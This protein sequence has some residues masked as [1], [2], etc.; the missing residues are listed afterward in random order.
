VHARCRSKR[1]KS[2]D[3]ARVIHRASGTIAAAS[4]TSAKSANPK[5]ACRMTGVEQDQ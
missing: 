5:G 2:L 1:I 4:A 3:A